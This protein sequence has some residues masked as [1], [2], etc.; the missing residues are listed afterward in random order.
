MPTATARVVTRDVI[1]QRTTLLRLDE[2]IVGTDYAG[3]HADPA[4]FTLDAVLITATRD[5]C[6]GG[7]WHLGVVEASGR[8]LVDGDPTGP[9][10][11]REYHPDHMNRQYRHA[12]MPTALAQLV[13]DELTGGG[14]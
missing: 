4:R 1:D 12:D 10:V 8:C 7:T 13:H 5:V 9:A 2:P 14:E 6:H 11:R 3:P